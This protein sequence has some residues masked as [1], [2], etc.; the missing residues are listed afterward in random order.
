MGIG[1]VTLVTKKE[2]IVFGMCLVVYD[3]CVVNS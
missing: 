1:L 2:I 3:A